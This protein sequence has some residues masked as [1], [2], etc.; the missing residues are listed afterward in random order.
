[1]PHHVVGRTLLVQGMLSF[2]I[3]VEILKRLT[4]ADAGIPVIL[5]EF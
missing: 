4:P 5:H 2:N 1:M 3:P